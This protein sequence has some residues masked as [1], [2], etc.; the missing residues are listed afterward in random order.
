MSRDARCEHRRLILEQRPG[1]TLG[2]ESLKIFDL[3]AD[4]DIL[5]RDAKLL[6]NADNDAAFGGAVEL[7]K[8]NAGNI[9][10][11]FEYARLLQAVLT[12]RRVH[13]EQRFMGRIG[14]FPG[15]HPADFF[16]FLDQVDLGM[17]SSRGVDQ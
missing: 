17:K 15:D 6:L 14:L 7:G 3:L 9:G 13:H 11:F 8:D 2:I 16:E 1:K 12:R 5:Y 10:R 4:A